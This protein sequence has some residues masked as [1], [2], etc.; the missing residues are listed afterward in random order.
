M[1]IHVY[2]TKDVSSFIDKLPEQIPVERNLRVV[3]VFTVIYFLHILSRSPQE[4]RA[5]FGILL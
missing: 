3:C 2:I 4:S 5:V 1:R